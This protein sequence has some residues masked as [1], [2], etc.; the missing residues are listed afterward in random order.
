MLPDIA[1]IPGI[2]EVHVGRAARTPESD[3]TPVDP[4]AVASLVAQLEAW[5]G[6]RLSPAILPLVREPFSAFVEAISEEFASLRM[7][8]ERAAAQ[9]SDEQ[10]FANLDNEANSVGTL[11]QHIGGNLRSRWQDFRTTDGEK[12]DRFRDR[13]FD[14]GLSRA[15]V[16]AKWR[17]GWAMLQDALDSLTNCRPRHADSHPRTVGES[18]RAH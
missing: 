7:L 2:R 4:R 8:V 10:F 12:P 1:A 13:E 3:T 15:E 18:C 11:M 9:V 14:A 16:E 5:R 17:Q 6:P